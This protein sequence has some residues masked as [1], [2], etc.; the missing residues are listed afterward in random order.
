MSLG[1]L[2]VFL[3]NPLEPKNKTGLTKQ[4][5]LGVKKQGRVW[6]WWDGGRGGK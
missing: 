3:L 6:M 5:I 4:T 1:S 2:F